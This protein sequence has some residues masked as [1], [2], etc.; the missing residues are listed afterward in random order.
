VLWT[1]PAAQ[2]GTAAGGAAA[3]LLLY[4]AMDSR[5]P[6]TAVALRP[7]RHSV[8]PPKTM[9]KGRPHT[10]RI[11]LP[12][13]PEA[14]PAQV[15]PA[16]VK[17]IL[18]AP[19]AAER[20]EWGRLL[21]ER[22]RTPPE[23][24]STAGSGW[25][26]VSAQRGGQRVRPPRSVRLHGFVRVHLHGA[27]WGPNTSR[28]GQFP[29]STT[30]P[31]PLQPSLKVAASAVFDAPALVGPGAAPSSALAAEC[32][33][34]LLEARAQQRAAAEAAAGGLAE[35]LQGVMHSGAAVEGWLKRTPAAALE[36]VAACAGWARRDSTRAVKPL[37]C[38]SFC[39]YRD[40]PI[41][42]NGGK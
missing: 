13:A 30:L 15:W 12:A 5:R 7:D 27:A 41:N 38:V 37:C 24:G 14:A 40:S 2:H 34:E 32:R 16:C 11:S 26:N 42:K 23:D 3:F 20:T 8:A 28:E 18:A 21:G 39:P 33:A 36:C 35:E 4:E 1:D 9:R 17:L 25:K 22:G 31:E 6:A 10:F 19:S 29:A